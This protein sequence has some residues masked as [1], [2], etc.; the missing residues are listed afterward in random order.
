MQLLEVNGLDQVKIESGFFGTLQVLLSAEA[1]ECN[2]LNVP[3][4]PRLRC[5]F[6]TTSIVQADVT[7]HRLDLVRS[8]NVDGSLYIIRSYN[9][10]TKMGKQT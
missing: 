6:V 7:L 4:R 3:F 9:I 1:G 2:C 10:V 8:H 5:Y